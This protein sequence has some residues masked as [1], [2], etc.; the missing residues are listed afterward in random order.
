MFEV[1]DGD[2]RGLA[3]LDPLLDE[4]QGDFHER[5]IGPVDQS[6]MDELCMRGGRFPFQLHVL[7]STQSTSV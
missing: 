5:V 1:L 7:T 3:G 2:Q 4:G 6:R